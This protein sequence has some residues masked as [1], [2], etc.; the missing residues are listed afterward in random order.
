MFRLGEK[1][2]GNETAFRALRNAV[3]C[4][5]GIQPREKESEKDFLTDDHVLTFNA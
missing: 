2:D 1:P 4:K 3:L 5:M